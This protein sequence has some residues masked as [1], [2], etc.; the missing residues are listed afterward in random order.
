MAY[1]VW[2]IRKLAKTASNQTESNQDLR[3]RSYSIGTA[4]FSICIAIIAIIISVSSIKVGPVNNGVEGDPT[5]EEA[6][7]MLTIRVGDRARAFNEK[8]SIKVD[9][10]RYEGD[11]PS[12]KV[13]ATISSPDASEVTVEGMKVGSELTYKGK[14][15][16]DIQ[17]LEV[18][19][20]LARFRIV[21]KKNS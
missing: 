15:T 19:A 2:K 16:Y 9:L 10:T 3:I 17:V 18:T 13:F 4:W 11:P 20:S 14:A 12:Y 7:I 8:L 5:G 1:S 21:E 6:Q